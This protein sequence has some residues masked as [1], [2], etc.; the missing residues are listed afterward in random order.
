MVN[1]RKMLGRYMDP[2]GCQVHIR[3]TRSRWEQ[4]YTGFFVSVGLALLFGEVDLLA[5]FLVFPFYAAWYFGMKAK[6]TRQ[7]RLYYQV[8]DKILQTGEPQ[9]VPYDK[10][11]LKKIEQD[12]RLIWP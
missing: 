7:Y 5:I 2:F 12:P 3:N 6:H 9:W 8:Q 11:R 10:F 1:G 4:W